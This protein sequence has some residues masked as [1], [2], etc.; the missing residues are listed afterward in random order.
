MEFAK[1]AGIENAS[2]KQLVRMDR[3]KK[4]VWEFRKGFHIRAASVR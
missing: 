2:G 4:R 1:A 3:M